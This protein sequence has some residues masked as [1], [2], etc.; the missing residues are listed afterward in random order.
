VLHGHIGSLWNPATHVVVSKRLPIAG[1]P[2]ISPSLSRWTKQRVSWPLNSAAAIGTGPK[3]ATNRTRTRVAGKREIY[4]IGLCCYRGQWIPK[5]PLQ[6]AK[7][8]AS[9]LLLYASLRHLC[10]ALSFCLF[11]VRESTVGIKRR[12]DV[13]ALIPVKQNQEL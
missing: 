3:A 1:N 9:Y 11:A 7:E 12:T 2:V 10:S 8:N 4:C 5:L 6:N 13:I